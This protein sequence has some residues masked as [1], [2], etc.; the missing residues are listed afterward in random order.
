M[1]GVQHA[2]PKNFLAGFAFLQIRDVP[3][4]CSEHV[5]TARVSM[6]PAFH[7]TDTGYSLARLKLFSDSVLKTF[8][9][10]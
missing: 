8:K 4:D 9:T 7:L 5:S 6:T 2:L 1:R 10:F 3:S